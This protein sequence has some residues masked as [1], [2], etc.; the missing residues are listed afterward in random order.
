MQNKISDNVFTDKMP[1]PRV[2]GIFMLF[3]V[4]YYSFSFFL[5]LKTAFYQAHYDWKNLKIL[6]KI[7][8][9]KIDSVSYN[10]LQLQTSKTKPDFDNQLTYKI[11][12]QG[13]S[14]F[15]RYEYAIKKGNTFIFK[16]LEWLTDKPEDLS[17]NV[18]LFSVDLPLYKNQKITAV[19]IGDEWI[20]EN[21]AK[22]LRRKLSQKLAVDFIGSKKDVFNYAYE[23]NKH[24]STSDIAKII[25]TLPEADYL[26]LFFD[27]KVKTEM[28]TDIENNIRKMA[29]QINQKKYKK[30]FWINMPEAK[31]LKIKNTYAVINNTLNQIKSSKITIINTND[32]LKPIKN[33]QL[34]GL[35]YLNKSGYE[36]IADFIEKRIINND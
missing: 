4:L 22:Y 28:A 17:R 34:S 20:F 16:R 14:Y 7:D 36:K 10:Y 24:L 31:E 9:V 29:H 6:N 23:G 18:K 15:F 27:G 12:S 19:T 13:E 21:D 8:A 1:K 3:F 30:V 11:E 33:Y 2:I 26:I 5:N 25:D 32:L 35:A